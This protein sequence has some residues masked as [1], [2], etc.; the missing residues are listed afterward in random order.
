[1]GISNFRPRKYA[2]NAGILLEESLPGLTKAMRTF[3][4]SPI[5]FPISGPSG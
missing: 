3:Y 5:G 4:D 1:M 2:G